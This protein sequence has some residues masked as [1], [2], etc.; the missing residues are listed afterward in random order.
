MNS[1]IQ[2]VGPDQSLQVFGIRLLG[3][4][5]LTAHKLLL[6]VCFFIF[7]YIVCALLRALAKAV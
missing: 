6:T 1:T 3:L 5:A 2:F 4:N 7:L